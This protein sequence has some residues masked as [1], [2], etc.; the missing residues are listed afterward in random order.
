MFLTS[1]HGDRVRPWGIT[2]F[3]RAL[4]PLC[5]LKKVL[6]ALHV[7]LDVAVDTSLTLQYK[8][9]I[10]TGT[11]QATYILKYVSEKK[12]ELYFPLEIIAVVI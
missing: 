2:L 1:L 9:N 3:G 11:L 10:Y 12:Y 8:S 6:R 4:G 5:L 7:H